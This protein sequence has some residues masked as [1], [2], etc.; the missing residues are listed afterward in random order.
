MRYSCRLSGIK[1]SI[2]ILMSK[3]KLLILIA[4]IIGLGFSVYYLAFA[5]RAWDGQSRFTVISVSDGVRVASFDPRTAEGIKIIFPPN[6]M[7]G[8]TGGK[9][10]WL[11]DKVGRADLV[12]ENLGILYTTSQ[13]DM[14]WRDRWLWW[15]WGRKVK[16]QEVEAEQW[17]KKERTVDGAEVWRLR[18]TWDTAAREMLAS[19]AVA[20]ER[21][22]VTVVNMTD[23][24]GLAVRVARRIE[25]SGL[26]VVATQTGEGG[27]QGCQVRSSKQSKSKIGVRLMVRSLGCSWG[28][29]EVGEN[30]VEL[31]FGQR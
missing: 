4:L 8:G 20:E 25:N 13:S 16:W 30:E 18:E 17:M 29:A 14:D 9:G 15:G 26:R 28:E 22:M 6:W 7:I 21:L 23:E 5:R 1:V 19:R 24:P 12:A 31:F 27:I 3:L 10:E 11:A 2:L